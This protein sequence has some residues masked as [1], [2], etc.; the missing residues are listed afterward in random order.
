MKLDLSGAFQHI[1]N[2][3]AILKIAYLLEKEVIASWHQEQLELGVL[4]GF[5]FL[6][7]SGR[8]GELAWPR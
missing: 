1:R 8:R 4:F 7:S 6:R 2:V 3:E 5:V